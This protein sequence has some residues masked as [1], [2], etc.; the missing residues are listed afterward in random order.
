[1]TDVVFGVSAQSFLFF[2]VVR[3]LEILERVFEGLLEEVEFL[4]VLVLLSKMG[5]CNN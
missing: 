3:S 2:L 1:M 5:A 4:T